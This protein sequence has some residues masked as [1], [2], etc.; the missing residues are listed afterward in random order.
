MELQGLFSTLQEITA[1]PYPKSDEC[2]LD[3]PS[4]LFLSDFPTKILYA[5]LVSPMRATC[6]TNI[7]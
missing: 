4:G 3:F 5:L 7:I 1:D 2:T 6:P